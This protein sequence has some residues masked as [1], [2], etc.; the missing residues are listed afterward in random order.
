[1]KNSSRWRQARKRNKYRRMWN[2][3]DNGLYALALLNA[4]NEGIELDEMERKIKT[5]IENALPLLQSLQQATEDSSKGD[6][7]ELQL[8]E[9]TGITNE[10]LEYAYNQ[11]STAKEELSLD[12]TDDE[13]V[14]NI[15]RE[16]EAYASQ[17]AKR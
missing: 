12:S 15:L 17:R 11:L 9:D 14:R 6:I 10:Q 4:K 2:K 5:G 3:S 13:K 1:M 7:E 8:I 16:I